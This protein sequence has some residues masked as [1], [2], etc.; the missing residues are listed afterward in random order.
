MLIFLH[1]IN[2]IWHCD[3]TRIATASQEKSPQLKTVY[4]KWPVT[5]VYDYWWH[6]RVLREIS[7]H[8]NCSE[9]QGS[10]QK[11]AGVMT[12]C[13]PSLFFFPV[14]I[15]VSFIQKL[16]QRTWERFSLTAQSSLWIQ[17]CSHFYLILSP[18]GCSLDYYSIN[19]CKMSSN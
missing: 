18:A 9:G 14:L 5:S 7:T 15:K 13:S 3:D 1:Q 4:W 11:E 19:K 16:E 17:I 8:C 6:V 12:G 2:W 10:T